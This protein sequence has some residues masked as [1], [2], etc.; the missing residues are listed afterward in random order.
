MKAD[1]AVLFFPEL[2]KPLLNPAPGIRVCKDAN[3]DPFFAAVG[4]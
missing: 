1:G 3:R 2:R 4:N